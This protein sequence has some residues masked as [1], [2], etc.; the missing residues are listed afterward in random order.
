M[1]RSK[2]FGLVLPV[3]M[4]VTVLS[5]TSFAQKHRYLR[6][7]GYGISDGYHVA[8][9]GPNSDYYNPYTKHNSALWIQPSKPA[10]KQTTAPRSTV[11][12]FSKYPKFTSPTRHPFNR[13]ARISSSSIQESNN[14]SQPAQNKINAPDPDQLPPSAPTGSP[15]AFPNKFSTLN[16]Q[17]F[18][19]SAT[20][21]SIARSLPAPTSNRANLESVVIPGGIK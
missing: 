13:K 8:N 11:S 16:P 21:I 15:K 12:S 5:S 19:Q 2:H 3:I 14:S 18:P 6:W 20:P 4:V 9:P 7:V 17:R 10:P 1:F